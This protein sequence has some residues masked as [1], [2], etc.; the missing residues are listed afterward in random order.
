ME[1]HS[2]VKSFKKPYGLNEKFKDTIGVIRSHKSK[3]VRQID[4]ITIYKTLQK[5]L[6][7]GQ[8]ESH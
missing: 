7:I 5:K 3:N 6:K 2:T 8:H 1:D 4:K